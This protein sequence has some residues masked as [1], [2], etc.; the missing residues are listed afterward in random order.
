MFIIGRL[1]CCFSIKAYNPNTNYYKVLGIPEN[2]SNTQVKQAF[3]DFAKKYHPD[4]QNGNEEK[5]KE[6]NEAYQVLSD[7]SVKQ[8]YD[9]VRT[10]SPQAQQQYRD[11]SQYRQSSSNQYRQASGQQSSSNNYR[12]Y[13]PD[14]GW[15]NKSFREQ[16]MH[17]LYRQQ[18]NEKSREE[19]SQSQQEQMQRK[20]R[21]S[22]RSATRQDPNDHV[23]QYSE[24][25]KARQADMRRHHEQE[26]KRRME[27]EYEEYRQYRDESESDMSEKLK[28]QVNKTADGIA[29]SVKD[30]LKMGEQVLDMWAKFKQDNKK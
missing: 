26:E 1:R 14:E 25:V 8:E 9:Q 3:R 16:F 11:S 17:D 23:R 21:E 2:A 12:G 20:F 19:F 28:K 5:F 15:K 10:P 27:R 6:V 4:S 30:A 18:Q 24:E 13:Q 7:S 22:M 29:N